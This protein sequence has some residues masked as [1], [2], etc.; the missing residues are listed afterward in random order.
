MTTLPHLI[1]AQEIELLIRKHA[2]HTT[3]LGVK[4]LDSGIERASKEIADLVVLRLK[5]RD[6]K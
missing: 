4:I 1:E 2:W 5:Q 6:D 3:D